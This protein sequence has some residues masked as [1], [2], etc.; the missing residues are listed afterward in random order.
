MVHTVSP[1]LTVW[2]GPFDRT[3]IARL[4]VVVPG[5]DFNHIVLAAVTDHSLPAL[6]VEV[7][8]RQVSK[9]I[10]IIVNKK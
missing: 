2:L 6:G 4:A 7:L 5:Q 10:M 3:D 1:R 9:L 8:V